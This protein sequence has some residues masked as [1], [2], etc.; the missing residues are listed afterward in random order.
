M[1]K[2]FV[3]ILFNNVA[4][5]CPAING[6]A[7]VAAVGTSASATFAVPANCTSVAI[8]P[9]AVCQHAVAP[10]TAVPL[11]AHVE[12]LDS[13]SQAVISNAAGLIPVTAGATYSAQVTWVAGPDAALPGNLVAG[14]YNVAIALYQFEI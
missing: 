4:V 1:S 13:M 14:D 8:V 12:L 2:K 7:G 10:G 11:I 3:P 9:G 6:V 5:A